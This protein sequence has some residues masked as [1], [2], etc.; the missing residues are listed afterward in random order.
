MDGLDSLKEIINDYRNSIKSDLS[1]EELNQIDEY[2]NKRL[3][4]LFQCYLPILGFD[5]PGFLDWDFFI[6]D[7]SSFLV[8]I[9]FLR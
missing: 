6:S 2:I 1:D 5:K 9:N 4:N 3:S 7:S 8:S